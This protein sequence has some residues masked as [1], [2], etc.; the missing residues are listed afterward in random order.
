MNQ[1]K[2]IIAFLFFGLTTISCQPTSSSHQHEGDEHS[3][4][5]GGHDDHDDHE[6]EVH[7][8]M[9][10]FKSMEMQI[11]NIPEINIGEYVLTN[12][13]LEVPP[14]NEAS[15]TAVIGANVK[16]INVIEGEKVKKNQV[17]AY[18]NHP[19][20]IKLQTDY[21]TKINQ[22]KFLEEEYNRQKKLYEE[23]VGSGREY[24][25]ASSDFFST[26]GEVKGLEAQLKMLHLNLN[27]IKKGEIYEN[28]P[29]ISPLNGY[30][31]LVEVKTGQ[32]VDP[33]KEMFEV[34]NLDDIHVDLM[35][36][37]K[38]ISKIQ[39]GQEV[40]F[41]TEVNP[42]QK[43]KA[44]VFNVGRSFEEGPKAIHLH[45]DIDGDKN[46]LIPGTYCKGKI[47]INNVFTT[48]LPEDALVREDNNMYFFTVEME[49]DEY[50]FKPHKVITGEKDNGFVQVK[51]LEELNQNQ[52]VAL[53]N[54]YYLMA[55]MKKAE[56]EHHH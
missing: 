50:A 28:V 26:K 12:G 35:V 18:L 24:Q 51:F 48:A 14:Q 44:S 46:G 7:L 3:H 22:L 43:M 33:Q 15:V 31:K 2:Y 29:V 54:A 25:K 10:Q 13:S 49:E 45:A 38:D 4:E 1:Y 17:L 56:A 23:K 20:L 9:L 6:E 37:E 16:K 42:K 36:F 30:I 55:E 19:N 8:S 27:K 21:V 53:N 40:L 47:M 39:V 32:Y 34:I 11:G 5:E 41:T 52:K